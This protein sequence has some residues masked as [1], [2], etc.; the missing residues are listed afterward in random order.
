MFLC[1]RNQHLDCR[2]IFLWVH[3]RSLQSY[4]LESVFAIAFI[5]S[6]VVLRENLRLDNACW[7]K[8]ANAEIAFIQSF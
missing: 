6:E 5:C 1:L 4:L 8:K 7:S 2:L 3:E